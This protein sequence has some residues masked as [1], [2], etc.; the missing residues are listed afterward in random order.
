MKQKFSIELKNRFSC[1][2][3]VEDDAAL[4][5]ST[6]ME[7]VWK[8]FK[9]TYNE[10]SKKVLGYQRASN[11]PWIS[12]DSWNQIDERK[13][14]K[15]KVEAVKSQRIKDRLRADYAEKARS[16]KRSLQQD[17]RRWANNLAR[18]AE[19]AFQS[20]NMKGVYES[21]KKLCNSQQRKMEVIKDKE[22][23]LLTTE[24]AVLQRWKEHFSEVLNRLQPETP[25]EVITD[26]V[27]EI[28]VSTEY[29]AKEEIKS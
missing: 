9:D 19:S 26:G 5:D 29:I 14:L 28:D 8:T 16:V 17:K 7:K 11:K 20:G 22:G 27:Q 24:N 23:K 13:E 1:L 2:E 18:D 10:T 4:T 6:T 3:E 21:T 25:A 12:N 15:K